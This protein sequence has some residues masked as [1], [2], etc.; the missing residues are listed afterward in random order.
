MV[1]LQE[2]RCSGHRA[3][4]TI[5]KLGF[6]K[7]VLVEAQGFSGGI[8]LMWNREDIKVQLLQENGHFLYVAVRKALQQ[9]GFLRWCMLAREN[10]RDTTR[11]NDLQL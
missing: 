1:A 9:T 7:F 8:W 4:A 5:N 3:R 6:K 11:G 2:P 10:R